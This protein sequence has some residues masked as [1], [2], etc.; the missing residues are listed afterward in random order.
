MKRLWRKGM[1]VKMALVGISVIAMLSL[2]APWL[3]PFDPL[4]VNPA[5][6][7]QPPNRAHLLGTD[8]L[9][10]DVLSRLM[11]GGQ[12]S[13]TVGLIAVSIELSAGTVVGLASGYL[14]GTVDAV[15]MRLCDVMLAVPGLVLALFIVAIL[16]PGLTNVMVALGIGG[17][18]GVTRL[19]RGAT[20]AVREREYVES[21]R[22]AGAH[23]VQVMARHVL[24]NVLPPILVLT[25]LDVGTIILAGAGLSFIGLGAQP[26]SAEWG[27]MLTGARDYFTRAWWL[28]VF[29]GLAIMAVVLCLNVIGD[30]V[31]DML[32]PWLRQAATK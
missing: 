22:A 2:L 23:A 1:P 32:D 6:R 17:I 19:V 31:R 7:L 25:T 24:P 13:L 21:A 15:V 5:H 30:A 12:L 10:R 16:G 14:G 9:G 27:A 18:P 11:W 20:L 8:Q 28:S 29:P 4:A 26:P 3:A